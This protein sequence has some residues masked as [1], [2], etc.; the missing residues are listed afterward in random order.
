MHQ[1]T[2]PITLP[3]TAQPRKD[4]HYSRHLLCVLQMHIKQDSIESRI[5]DSTLSPQPK[6]E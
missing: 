2:H 1:G 6:K 4:L 5:N 3:N